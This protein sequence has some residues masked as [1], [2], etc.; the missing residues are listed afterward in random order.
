[1]ALRKDSKRRPGAVDLVWLV[2]QFVT[3]IEI[4]ALVIDCSYHTTHPN[5]HPASVIAQNPPILKRQVAYL[6]FD[7]SLARCSHLTGIPPN[8]QHFVSQKALRATWR[9][10]RPYPM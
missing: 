7:A 5:V 8:K 6:F 3:S 9:A 2:T 4:P 1:M 10:L